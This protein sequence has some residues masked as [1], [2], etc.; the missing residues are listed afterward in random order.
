MPSL[1][2]TALLTCSAQR[3]FQVVNDVGRYPEFLPWCRDAE[4]LEQAQAPAH[5]PG[6][7]TMVASLQL[8]AK[9]LSE[10]FTTRNIAVPCERVELELVSGPFSS[11]HGRWE[12]TAIGEAGCR[13]ELFVDFEF[14]R[15]L[16]LLSRVVAGS[17]VGAADRIL[18]AFC[19]RAEAGP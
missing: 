6:A 12:I 10:T 15:G 9:G 5:G 16:A 8:S 18:D 7:Q 17:L 13:T 1:H 2:R 14:S 4:V 3:M 19:Q 11:F